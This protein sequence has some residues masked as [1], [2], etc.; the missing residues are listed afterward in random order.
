MGRLGGERRRLLRE[1]AEALNRFDAVVVTEYRAGMLKKAGLTRP[2]ILMMHGAGDALVHDEHLVREFD[3]VLVAGPKIRDYFIDK[4]LTT[5]AACKIIGYPKFELLASPAL[6]TPKNALPF[7]G[8]R[9][10]VL[11]NPHQREPFCSYDAFLEPLIKGF[12]A[13]KEQG[14]VIAPH[15]KMF[16]KLRLLPEW[17]L[18][19][20]AGGNIIVDTRSPALL[21]MTY[22][23]NARLYVGDTSSQVYEF[24]R[25]PRPCVF[26]NPHK[27]EWQNDPSFKFWQAG[28]VVDDP[29]DLMNALERA[30]ARHAYYREAQERLMRETFGEDFAALPEK[31]DQSA[32]ERGAEAI[33]NYLARSA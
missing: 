6:Q 11:Y 15:V 24:L 13:H 30:P 10:F 33:L 22:T 25:R 17:A 9:P 19:R 31:N 12:R 14:L 29:A 4:G 2:L 8:T 16:Q 18:H 23:A 27:A 28:E 21:D 20:K 32:A 1:N 7:A 26:L 5:A 3:L